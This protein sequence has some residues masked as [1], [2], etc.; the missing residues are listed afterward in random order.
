MEITY[1]HRLTD[2]KLTIF[3]SDAKSNMLFDLCDYNGRIWLTGSL[4]SEEK[5]TEI[6][7]ANIGKG[8]FNLVIINQGMVHRQKISLN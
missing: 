3:H 5:Q 1:P 4:S 6:D 7:I 8:D 2:E